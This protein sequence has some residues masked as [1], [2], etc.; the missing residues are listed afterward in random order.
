VT[1]WEKGEKM[2]RKEILERMKA[3]DIDTLRIDFSDMYGITRSKIVPAKRLDEVLEEGINCA[4]PTF[5]LDLAYNIPPGTGTADEV[6]YEDMAIIPD[7]DTFSVVP[8]QE[9]TARFIG[10]IY[11]D[12]KPFPY[13][14]RWLLKRVFKLYEEKGL[15]PIAATEL[16][17][18]VFKNDGEAFE[19]YCD[20]P[21][22][23]YTMGI[24]SDPQGLLRNLQNILVEMGLDV[25]YSNHEFFQSQ[26]E[27]NW[28]HTDALTVADQTFTFKNV[29]K[30]V[31]F[32]NGLILTFMGR[33]K[34][35]MGGSGYHV[36]FSINDPETGKNLFD[37]PGGKDGISDLMRHFIGGQMA[38]AKGMTLF[39]APTI[40]SYKRYVLNA[41]A[42]YYLAWGLD[43]RTTYIRV[44][45]ERGGATRVENRAACASA[46]PYL[47]LAVGLIAGLDG[48][49]NKTE[50]GDY[51]VGD[52]YTE[53]PGKFETVPLYL[54]DAIEE[55]KKDT[56]LCEAI[57]P[58]I[59]QNYTC[60]KENEVE[61][62]RTYV[63]DWEF[64]EYCYHL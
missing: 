10:D 21:S 29:C 30:E 53:E 33:P 15:L 59:I 42:P 23:V 54:S 8:Y 31:A 12:E 60:V 20:K 3:A 28:K 47:V 16:E 6:N 22:N 7:P 26:Y 45:R 5:S 41:F 55:L 49:E 14:P 56:T 25:L 35:E 18:F 62:F 1:F 61:R 51:Y 58:E 52:I 4:K 19:Y 13:S 57:G 43:N 36:H 63:T 27:I 44:P 39:F 34:N 11:V 17:F 38:H 24:R 40:N 2:D 50:P 9:N 37:D 48:I 46:N 32:A 64:N